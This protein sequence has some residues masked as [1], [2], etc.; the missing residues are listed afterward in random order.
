MSD[1]KKEIVGSAMN[2]VLGKEVDSKTAPELQ[3]IVMSS[4]GDVSEVNFDCTNLVYLTSAGLRVLLLA[5]QE[6]DDKGGSMTL[7]NVS[8]Y[9]KSIFK[10]T[11]FLNILTI[12]D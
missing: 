2:I 1:I 12:I 6:M 11:G 8:P 3:E 7:K 5:L 9:I 4:V 10:M